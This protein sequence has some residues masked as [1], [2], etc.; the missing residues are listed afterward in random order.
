MP[1]SYSHV[2]YLSHWSVPKTPGSLS[3]PEQYFGCEFLALA[4]ALSEQWVVS[5]LALA[6]TARRHRQVAVSHR[7]TAEPGSSPGNCGKYSSCQMIS[8]PKSGQAPCFPGSRQNMGVEFHFP[9]AINKSPP[10]SESKMVQKCYLTLAY[11]WPFRLSEEITTL[12]PAEK[13]QS[14]CRY[15]TPSITWHEF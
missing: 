6:W 12:L 10:D 2:C 15:T 13:S 8:S 14:L 1:R 5:R 7:V 3:S 11:L 4:L 9:S